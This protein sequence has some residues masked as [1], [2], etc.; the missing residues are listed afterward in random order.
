MKILGSLR[1]KYNVDSYVEDTQ[2]RAR[3]HGFSAFLSEGQS[4]TGSVYPLN[5]VELWGG[6]F[7]PRVRVVVSP[8]VTQIYFSVVD[9]PSIDELETVL[10]NLDKVLDRIDMHFQNCY[11]K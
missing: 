1:W 7:D 4:R 5:Q 8:H 9:V 11:K 6:N 2:Q 10:N 3:E